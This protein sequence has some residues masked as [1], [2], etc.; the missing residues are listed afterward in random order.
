MNP[1]KKIRKRQAALPREE[2]IPRPSRPEKSPDPREMRKARYRSIG[3]LA[4]LAVVLLVAYWKVFRFPFIQDDWGWMVRFQNESPPSLL[5]SIFAPSG[6]LF[7]RPLGVLYLYLMYLVFGLNPLP[8]HIF[9]IAL[10]FANACLIIAVVRLITRDEV[11]AYATAFMYSV[12]VSVNLDCLLWAVGIFDLGGVFFFLLSIW[13]FLRERHAGS[14]ISYFLGCLFKEMVI[15]LPVILFFYTLVERGRS[16]APLRIL[17]RKR[18]LWITIALLILVGVKLMGVLPHRLAV[19]HPYAIEFAGHLIRCRFLEYSFVAFQSFYPFF[20]ALNGIGFKLVLSGL[21]LFFLINVCLV[22]RVRS[23][24]AAMRPLWLLLIWFAGALLPVLFLLN[25]AYRYYAIYLLPSFIAL[26]LLQVGVFCVSLGL[27]RRCA[28]VLI[29]TVASVAVIF[30]E[31]QIHRML[32]EGLSQKILGDG[33]NCLIRRAAVV[34]NVRNGLMKYLP[35]PPQG[36]IIALG[37][38]ELGAFGNNAGPRA[39]YGD[40]SIAVY[41]IEAF[42]VD[43]IGA[44]IEGGVEKKDRGFP[45]STIRLGPD[46]VERLFAFSMDGTKLRPAKLLGVQQPSESNV[47]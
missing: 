18:L 2:A 24:M 7:Y 19:S 17:L 8:F 34:E 32:E 6:V 12:A 45:E 40:K 26:M 29:V 39:W 10:H 38:V 13:L 15:V 9:A 35:A 42:R 11:I 28:H 46:E 30:S 4:A 33:T 27:G 47:K 1:G 36:A 3:L 22:S 16:R 21:L 23:N 20:I 37:K 5:K 31:I 41:P 44:F 14:A 43:S 25:H